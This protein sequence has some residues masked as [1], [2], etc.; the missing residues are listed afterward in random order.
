MVALGG[1]TKYNSMVTKMYIEAGGQE[2]TGMDIDIF[3]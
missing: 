1:D 3:C 2:G